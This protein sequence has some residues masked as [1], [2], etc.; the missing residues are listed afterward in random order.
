MPFPAMISLL[1]FKQAMSKVR[2]KIRLHSDEFEIVWKVKI[3]RA[4]V[5]GGSIMIKKSTRCH[6]PLKNIYIITTL[7]TWYYYIGALLQ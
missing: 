1:V 3:T 5:D 7:T 4:L 6:Q 2:H